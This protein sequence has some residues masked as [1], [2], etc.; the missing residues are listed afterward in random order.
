MPC[1]E[2]KLY[3]CLIFAICFLWSETW[4]MGT[5]ILAIILNAS[6]G[7]DLRLELAETMNK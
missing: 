6:L 4:E 1:K 5:I 7:P 2:I 3:V